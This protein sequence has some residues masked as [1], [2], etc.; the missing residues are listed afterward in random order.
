MV[1][2]LVIFLLKQLKCFIILM[3]D[4]FHNIHSLHTPAQLVRTNIVHMASCLADVH[5]TI[6]AVPRP[7]I[8]LHRQV[9]I[10]FNGAKR[11]CTGGIDITSV[12]EII[13]NALQQMNS[14][15]LDQLPSY[16]QRI[17]PGRLQAA[18]R[19]LR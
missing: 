11:T 9:D 13:Q 5:P 6:H 16:M 4:D 12:T 3:V 10:N 7:V 19:E 1:F 15:F 18:L 8:S 14:Q 17:D 2:T